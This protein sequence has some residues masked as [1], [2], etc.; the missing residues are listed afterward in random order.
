MFKFC[1]ICAYTVFSYVEE[2]VGMDV[3]LFF[4]TRKKRKV[5]DHNQKKSCD[6][7]ENCRRGIVVSVVLI[8]FE[9]RTSAVMY[10]L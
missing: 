10:A 8:L 4:S 6:E 5:D 9:F 3:C 1:N 7:K 2:L